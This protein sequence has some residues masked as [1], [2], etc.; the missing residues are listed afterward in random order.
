MIRILSMAVRGQIALAFGVALGACA[1]IPGPA[2]EAVEVT[3]SDTAP[4]I[5]PLDELIAQAAV[6]N[7]PDSIG[8]ELAARAARL[9]AKGAA[10]RAASPQPPLLAVPQS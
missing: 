10:M 9:R 8:A 3:R 2:R 5:L 1:P 6:S 4:V 7:L